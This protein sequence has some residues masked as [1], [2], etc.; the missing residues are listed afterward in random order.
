MKKIFL[1]LLRIFAA[2]RG[3]AADV[4][5]MVG[6]PRLPGR[7]LSELPRGRLVQE[8]DRTVLSCE[9]AAMPEV[10]AA[11]GRAFQVVIAYVGSDTRIVTGMFSGRDVD[12]I[13]IS[14]VDR[15]D[16]SVTT[17]GSVRTI[18]PITVVSVP[19][20][21]FSMIAGASVG[22]EHSGERDGAAGR[23]EQRGTKHSV[24]A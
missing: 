24:S 22:P 10:V 17:E 8:R 16:L 4:S 2:Q 11:L 15:S 7:V 5:A 12:A 19:V 1:G 20:V 23:S 9:G 14:L 18:E 3:N 13:L 21:R 6:E